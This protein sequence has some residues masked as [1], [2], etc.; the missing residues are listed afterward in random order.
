MSFAVRVTD[1]CKKATKKVSTFAHRHKIQKFIKNISRPFVIIWRWLK[2]CLI[3]RHQLLI[4]KL[5]RRHKYLTWRASSQVL[6]N[7]IVTE[8]QQSRLQLI[9]SLI[10]YNVAIVFNRLL[11]Y[12]LPLFLAAIVIG[13]IL[14]ST[15][16]PVNLHVHAT[17]A[18]WKL[19][20]PG[21][22]A[23]NEW[24]ML[25][26]DDTAQT[27]KSVTQQDANTTEKDLILI[28]C[29]RKSPVMIS[30]MS[31]PFNCY[32][33][34]NF[35]D[36]LESAIIYEWRND[37]AK[38]PVI[39]W[40]VSFENK[41]V[42]YGDSMLVDTC[43]TDTFKVQKRL[44]PNILYDLPLQGVHKWHLQRSIRVS[45]LIFNTS[46][47]LQQTRSSVV[48]GKISLLN[49]AGKDS[50]IALNEGDKLH[51]TFRDPVDLYLS[52][53]PGYVNIHTSGMANS[54]E[55]GPEALGQN[56]NK[57]PRWLKSYTDE[58]PYLLT[59]VAIILPILMAVIVRQRKSI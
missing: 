33:G 3:I 39:K 32:M 1:L 5:R 15:E 29:T 34:I 55:C 37:L 18:M 10:I 30:N 53:E 27:F 50:L 48:S 28:P 11:W 9:D 56:I 57:M 31:L 7:Q 23:F 44:K 42:K 13:S 58:S 24:D 20:E 2:T 4:W 6:G 14:H 8:A 21:A 38:P 25:C 16:V 47:G 51:L 45:E 12:I 59:L 46:P 52:T 41:K 36:S 40:D 17:G 35:A 19:A 54:I 26:N 22:N 43:F 49:I